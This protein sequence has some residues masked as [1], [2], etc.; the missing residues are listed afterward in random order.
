MWRVPASGGEP[1]LL[2]E[3]PGQTPRWSPDGRLIYFVD[4]AEGKNLWAVS[5]EDGGERPMTDLASR[6][7]NLGPIAL[8]TDGEQLFFAWEENLGDLWVMDV[9]EPGRE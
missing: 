1:E 5:V 3:R 9:A 8:A 6:P 2:T 7:G 4:V